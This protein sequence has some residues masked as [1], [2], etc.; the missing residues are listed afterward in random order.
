MLAIKPKVKI[1]FF[2]RQVVRSNWKKLAKN[3][4]SRFGMIVRG[5][6]RS[7]IGRPAKK[8]TT[9]PRTP[10]KAPRSRAP[11]DPFKLIFSIPELSSVMIGMVGFSKDQVPGLH[12][13]GG[14]ARR[15]VFEQGGF[16]HKHTKKTSGKYAKRRSKVDFKT[17]GGKVVAIPRKKKMTVKIPKRQFMEPAWVRA[18]PKIPAIWRGSLN[19]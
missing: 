11:G 2:G 8:K 15:T 14:T 9:R 5:N 12:E 16:L 4:L 19:R 10:P 18:K 13:H 3:P 7:E 17:R 1:N 6:A